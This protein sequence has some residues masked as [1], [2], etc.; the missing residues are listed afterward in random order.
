MSLAFSQIDYDLPE[1]LHARRENS[2]SNSND[3]V[4]LLIMD[5]YYSNISI[6]YFELVLS[7]IP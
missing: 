7:S 2:S 6:G 4:L 3:K 1:K 5:V